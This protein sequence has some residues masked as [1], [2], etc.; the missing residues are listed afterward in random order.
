LPEPPKPEQARL[1]QTR[2]PPVPKKGGQRLFAAGN[3]ADEETQRE[4]PR[5]APD[6]GGDS[7]DPRAPTRLAAPLHSGPE[8]PT[9]PARDAPSGD[10]FQPHAP[11]KMVH[12]TPPGVRQPP[13]APKT[14]MQSLRDLGGPSSS[15]GFQREAPTRLTTPLVDASIE[16]SVADAELIAPDVRAHSQLP[17]EETHRR[18]SPPPAAALPSEPMLDVPGSIPYGTDDDASE[19]ITAELKRPP[20]AARPSGGRDETVEILRAELPPPGA[21]KLPT[22]FIDRAR[23]NEPHD[24]D[25][26]PRP[27]P[28]APPGESVGS[29]DAVSNPFRA[30]AT[31]VDNRSISDV[32]P[33]LSE[34]DVEVDDSLLAEAPDLP[35]YEDPNVVDHNPLT[36]AEDRVPTQNIRL[37]LEKEMSAEQARRRAAEE[38][39]YDDDD[40]GTV[41]ISGD[42]LEEDTEAY[43]TLQRAAA[44]APAPAPPAPAPSAAR[45]PATAI[46][47]P[48]LEDDGGG[49]GDPMGQQPRTQAELIVDESEVGPPEVAR[50]KVIP[51]SWG[52]PSDEHQ[53]AQPP[54]AAAPAPE[55]PAAPKALKTIM[56]NLDEEDAARAEAAEAKRFKA[57]S[58]R[59]ATEGSTA[60]AATYLGECLNHL[61]EINAF[62]H[63][64]EP[65]QRRALNAKVFAAQQK[66]RR[67]LD[68]L[69]AR[70]EEDTDG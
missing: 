5:P 65:E 22:G 9:D 37:E 18:P 43:A 40:D 7:F 69:G 29:G 53:V 46:M 41:D 63:H 49:D 33:A 66:L 31:T 36:S 50:W 68:L 39:A 6:E 1:E 38:D 3:T 62:Q 21:P 61:E 64:L 35:A 4:G 60:I 51:T 34:L 10:N 55:P 30:A 44:P 45:G 8:G 70:V 16:L 15:E 48:P 32:E 2:K 27:V 17:Q 47:H 25:G 57:A 67:A 54:A 28:V 12:T 14:E 19:H 59:A 52:E 11:T 13:P 23:M 24:E 26:G 42:D 58:H 20:G 56:W